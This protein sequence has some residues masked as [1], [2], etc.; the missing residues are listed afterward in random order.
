MGIEFESEIPIEKTV[1]IP[2]AGMTEHYKKQGFKITEVRLDNLKIL[3]QYN[4]LSSQ[5]ERM[6]QNYPNA[7]LEKING[8]TYYVLDESR[9]NK[10]EYLMVKLE[11]ITDED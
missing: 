4:G 5:K 1:K 10:N 3:E 6:R 7:I 9:S 8:K 11:A 2:L